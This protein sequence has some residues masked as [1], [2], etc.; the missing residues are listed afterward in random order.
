MRRALTNMIKQ[1]TPKK[2]SKPHPK[3]TASRAKVTNRVVDAMGPYSIVWDT[4]V[5]GFCVRQWAAATTYAVKTRA[6][7][8]Q[9]TL[10]I[11]QHGSPWTPDTA[12]AEAKRLLG[13]IAA[14]A[15][16]ASERTREREMPLFSKLASRFMAEYVDKNTKPTTKIGYEV[17]I[18]LHMVPALG[19]RRLDAITD[20][21][22]ERLHEKISAKSPTQANR[23]VAVLSKMFAWA[24]K[25][26]IMPAGS[27]NPAKGVER[28]DERQSQRFLS[29]EEIARLGDAMAAAEADNSEHPS[30]INALRLLV[31]T[32]ARKSEITTAKWSYYDAE[33]GLLLLPDSK[34][35][36]KPIYL[37]PAALTVIDGLPRIEGNQYMLTG[38]VTGGHIVGLHRAWAR[39]RKTAGLDGVRIHDLRHSF[40]STAAARG[41]SLLMIGKLLGHA[42]AVTTQRYAHLAA[43]PLREL[44]DQAGKHIADAL[45]R[46]RPAALA[47]AS[48]DAQ[49][50]K[51]GEVIALH[52][53]VG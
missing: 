23:T 34:T 38:H 35:G 50:T 52:K 43:D 31:L 8:R 10:V 24:I 11:G 5:A 44:N 37:S 14:G 13:E 28:N 17:L 46:N 36:A 39:V 32:G 7:G 51:T 4:A 19:T 18:R 26:K 29:S 22:I 6:R 41:G 20:T 1:S 9:V 21:D 30:A 53:R 47:P 16:P 45:D 25:R 12:R 40:A 3:S 15:D 2:R 48:T 33:R 49:P 27:L 42:Q